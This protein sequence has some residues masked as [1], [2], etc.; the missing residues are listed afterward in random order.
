MSHTELLS[1]IGIILDV[2]CLGLIIF[3]LV[4]RK[5]RNKK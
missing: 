3:L 2:V 4:N 5:K 1:L